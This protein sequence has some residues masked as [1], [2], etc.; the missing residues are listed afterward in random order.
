MAYK[1]FEAKGMDNY[2]KEISAKLKSIGAKK[3]AEEP[4][5]A[6]VKISPKP[7]KGKKK[8]KKRVIK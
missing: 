4:D 2:V 1:I 5:E 3:E 6:A 7:H 8:I